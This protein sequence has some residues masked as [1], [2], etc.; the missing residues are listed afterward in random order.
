M[1]GIT[2]DQVER[3]LLEQEAVISRAR[4]QQLLLIQL[5]DQMQLPSADG[6]KSMREWLAGR[7]DISSETAY[8]LS[9][10]S[11]RLADSPDLTAQLSTADSTYDRVEATSR[12]PE[13]RRADSLEG[14]DIQ[15]L[16]SVASRL[17]R[18]GRV[19]DNQAHKAQHLTMQ[20]N[21]DESQWHVWGRLDGYGGAVVNKVLTEEA[22]L[23]GELPN[24]ERPGL[25]YRKAMALVNKCERSTGG[26]SSTPL[27]TVFVDSDGAHVESG[28]SVGPEILEKIACGGS[29]E[30][31]KTADGEP[32][33]VGRRKSVI[34]PRLRRFVLHRDGACTAEGCTSRYRLQ[35]HHKQPWSEGGPTDADNLV[36]LCWFHHHVVIHGWGYRVDASRGFRR[37]RFIPPG[38][39]PPRSVT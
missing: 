2:P 39:D 21:L 16:R 10:T 25:G 14:F 13:S 32:L 30:L 36:T 34:S 12:I 38:H 17:R 26:A 18:L 35:P 4:G 22:D 20:P 7:L 28:T 31:M 33:S 19:D 27:I 6:C 1:E 5:A 23:I 24:G 9:T 8:S 3:A 15:G 29:L 11:K 37:I